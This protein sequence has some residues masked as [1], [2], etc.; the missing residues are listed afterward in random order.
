MSKYEK[1]DEEKSEGLT[2]METLGL[3]GS[4]TSIRILKISN[5]EQKNT[6][7]KEEEIVLKKYFR[8]A[9]LLR[10]IFAILNR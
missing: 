1:C 5:R 3:G 7:Y 2:V 8:L 10:G 9:K 4:E 6:S